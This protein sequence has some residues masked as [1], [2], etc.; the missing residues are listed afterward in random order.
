MMLQRV[1]V[2]SKRVAGAAMLIAARRPKLLAMRRAAC[3]GEPDV[4]GAQ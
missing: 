2:A 1:A 4:D 3:Y